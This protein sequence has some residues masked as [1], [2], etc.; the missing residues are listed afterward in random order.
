M[1]YSRSLSSSRTF[2]RRSRPSPP[3]APRGTLRYDESDHY[4][5]GA[6]AGGQEGP[7]P[8]RGGGG[9][10]GDHVRGRDQRPDRRLPHGAPDEGGDRRRADRLRPG[11]A[12]EGGPG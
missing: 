1:R 4:G 3:V 5:G 8:H 11:H 6:G 7:E 12:P 9:H 10:G 2:S